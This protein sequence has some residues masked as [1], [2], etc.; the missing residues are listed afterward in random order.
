MGDEAR[1]GTKTVEPREA[2]NLVF[3]FGP[4]AVGKMTVGQ[5]LQKLTGY[6][7]LYNHMVVDLVTEFVDFGTPAFHALARPMTLQ[8]IEACATTGA[9]LIITHGLIFDRASTPGLLEEW[10]AP[11]RAAGGN[12][13]YVELNAP[14]D[15]RMQRN[16]TANRMAHKKTDW[17]TDDRM[18]EMETWGRW[19]S[20][21]SLPDAERQMIIDNTT[22]A[23]VEAAR[24]IA[25][26]F[27]L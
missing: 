27:A 14:L 21:G 1:P 25:A 8:L 6:K 2:P 12:V 7:L 13:F 23:P 15:V 20:D 19:T 10:S 5:E 22:V 11:H 26:R 24:M 17:A 18:R 3:I 4:S 9:G 16:R